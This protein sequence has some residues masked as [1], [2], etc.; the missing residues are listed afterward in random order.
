MKATLIV[1]PAL[2]LLATLYDASGQSVSVFQMTPEERKTYFARINAQAEKSWRELVSTLH[3]TLPD[4]LPSM[5]DDPRRPAGTYQKA[6]SSAWTDSSGNTYTR[7]AWGNWNNYDETKANPYPTLPD[8]L[9]CNNGQRVKDADTWWRVRRPELERMFDTAIFGKIPAR[10]PLPHWEVVSVGDSTVGRFS[11]SV[12]KLCGRVHHFSGARN[13]MCIEATLVVP[14]NTGNPVPVIV[15][16]GFILPPGITFPGMPRETG[17]AWTEQVLAKGWGYAIYVPT[18]VQPDNASGLREG[19]IGIATNGELRKPEDWGALRA[20]AWGASRLLDYLETDSLVDSKRVGIEGLSR[21]GKAAL[22]AM[23][24]DPRFA[25]ALVGSSG[26]GGATLYRREFGESM[27]NLCGTAAYH[28]FAGNFI[29]YA[30]RPD[31]LPVDSHELI[32]MCAPRPVFVSCG[33]PTVEG[34]WVDNAGQFKAVEAAGPVYTLLGKIP[35]PRGPMPLIDSALVSGDL[36]FRQ[37]HGGH[38]VGPNWPCFLD[39]AER[40]SVT[41]KR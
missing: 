17:P 16:L 12:K 10:V 33:S 11:V 19:I 1:I 4:S 31:L 13:N 20:W 14:A 23:A 29:T 28:W 25:I 27:G 39:F 15:E 8:P 24:Y 32:A 7:S 2:G 22:V 6:G 36:A 34:R 9:L 30:A 40:Y 35:L 5:S 21:Y 18:S 26:K 3:V 38:T 37:H 41:T